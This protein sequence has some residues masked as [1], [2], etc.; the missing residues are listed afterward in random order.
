VL[1]ASVAFESF[2][3]VRP[4]GDRLIGVV[5]NLVLALGG[6]VAAWACR[7][8]AQAEHGVPRSGWSWLGRACAVFAIS[9]AGF[10]AEYA[11]RTSTPQPGESYVDVLTVLVIPFAMVGLVRLAGSPSVTGRLL[12]VLDG[13][14]LGLS[15]LFVGWAAVLAPTYRDTEAGTLAQAAM[16]VFLAGSLAVF[17]LVLVLAMR[18]QGDRGTL[19][20]LVVGFGWLTATQVA[21]GE[22]SIR[23]TYRT[24]HP[25]LDIGWFGPFL[26]IALAARRPAVAEQHEAWRR[27]W[28]LSLLVPYAAFVLVAATSFVL[29]LRDEPFDLLLQATVAAVALLL[30]TRLLITLLENRA[31]TVDLE[32]RVDERSREVRRSEERLQSVLRYSSDVIALADHD[33]TLT[34]VSPATSAV[35]GCAPEAVRGRAFL[36]LVHVA[37][38]TTAEHALRSAADGPQAATTLSCRLS[39]D[40]NDWRPVEAT[41]S[42]SPEGLV[43]NLRDVSER[44]ALLDEMRRLALHDSL[45]SLPNRRLLHERVRHALDRAAR[46]GEEVS[47][48]YVDLDHFKRVN[49][50]AGHAVGDE[51]LVQVADRLRSCLRPADTA[52]RL[53]GDEFAVLL[54]G[55]AAEEAEEVAHRLVEALSPGYDVTGQTVTVSASVGVRT[56]V[57]GGAS[58]DVL[59]R[60]ADVAMYQAKA[61]GRGRA[62]VFR[63]QMQDHLVAQMELERGLRKALAEEELTLVYQPIVDLWSGE[64]LGVEALV[65]WSTGEGGAVPP[66]LFIPLAEELGLIQELDRWVLRRACRQVCQWQHRFP[67]HVGLRA[68]VNLSALELHEAGLVDDVRQVLAETGLPPQCLTLEITEAAVLPDP[69]GSASVLAGLRQLGVSVSL[70]DFGTGSTSL[71]TLRAFP[72]D[73][74]KIDRMFV[75]ALE[76]DPAQRGLVQAIVSLA[77]ALNLRTVAEAVETSD[78]L[79]MLQ[80]MHCG[81]AQG[82][83]LAAPMAPDD[84]AV[85][86][87][88]GLPAL[89][90]VR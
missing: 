37:D 65:R 8:R 39:S 5:D 51:V 79:H 10:A 75:E 15:G 11:W 2:L 52:A 77:A 72:L 83:L 60:D 20:L 68:N 40:G 78:Q 67:R 57:G 25:L 18:W 48:L 1:A 47:L 63:Q 22:V 19:V 59:L 56:C 49:D 3:L 28:L 38:R 16:L 44:A 30:L 70:D 73:E 26:L 86:F 58:S 31:L 84:V 42:A 29:L 64:V 7:R 62:V 50:T 69:A 41:V 66:V 35:L 32:Q 24:G 85:L 6:G 90:A 46:S 14:V 80:A 13:L 89:G 21:Y 53:G 12:S 27:R 23:G 34:Y 9:E 17:A 55:T 61:D 45:T 54:E 87:A 74:I 76:D 36:D 71:A 88:R 82:H 81:S 4:F 43:L 33:G